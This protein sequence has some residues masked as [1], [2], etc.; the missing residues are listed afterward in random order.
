MGWWSY[1]IA[2]NIE[3]SRLLTEEISE[4]EFQ[5]IEITWQ[6]EKD[7]QTILNA[8]KSVAK[9]GNFGMRH[10]ISRDAHD[11]TFDRRLPAELTAGEI[12]RYKQVGSDA[13]QALENVFPLLAPVR[14]K[15]RSRE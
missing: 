6:A 10:R 13:G 7:P 11:R 8:A 4:D 2:N 14:Q 15:R 1:L 3:I 5:P 9:R 12:D